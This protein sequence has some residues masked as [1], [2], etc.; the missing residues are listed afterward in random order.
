MKTE[1]LHCPWQIVSTD[2]FT[3]CKIEYLVTVHYFSKFIKIDRI[4]CKNACTV[5]KKLKKLMARY[6]LAEV[7]ISDNG[8]QFTSEVLEKF[9]RKYNICHQTSSPHH[10]QRNG[11]A[12]SAVK[13]A[14]MLITKANDDGADAFLALLAHRN[15]PQEGFDE[16]PA[17]QMFGHRCI[18]TLPT[19]HHYCS[20][21]QRTPR[22]QSSCCSGTGNG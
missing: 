17:Q 13:T 5:V 7:L 3:C 4:E 8:P 21:T 15:T 2:L 18:T 11:K 16:S 20:L 9:T 14:K 1:F 6:G 10:P 19:L 12:E 22:G